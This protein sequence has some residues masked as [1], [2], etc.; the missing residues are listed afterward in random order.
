MLP[1][2]HD[3]THISGEVRSQILFTMRIGGISRKS[4]YHLE[5]YLTWC[6]LVG[7]ELRKPTFQTIIIIIR[8]PVSHMTSEPHLVQHATGPQTHP[9]TV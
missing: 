2:I 5:D 3:G 4:N 7:I 6:S 8:K 9:F 1:P